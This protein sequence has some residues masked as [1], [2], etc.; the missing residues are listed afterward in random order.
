MAEYETLMGQLNTITTD[1]TPSHCVQSLLILRRFFLGIWFFHE[2]SD[3]SRA[4]IVRWI[5][6]RCISYTDKKGF[7]NAKMEIGLLIALLTDYFNWVSST[8]YLTL[9]THDRP[10]QA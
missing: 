8:L 5:F 7:A 2:V 4:F 10:R 1:L 3:I 9:F 6:W